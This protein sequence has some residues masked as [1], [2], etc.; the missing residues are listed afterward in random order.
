M[1]VIKLNFHKTITKKY[2]VIIKQLEDNNNPFISS[3]GN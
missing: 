1:S 3:E 2:L